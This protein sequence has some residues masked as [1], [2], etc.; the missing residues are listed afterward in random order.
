MTSTWVSTMQVEQDLELSLSF[1]ADDWLAATLPAPGRS[2]DSQ[3]ESPDAID[4]EFLLYSHS[5]RKGGACLSSAQTI[6]T[7]I[8]PREIN[9]ISLQRYL[10]EL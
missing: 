3:T 6:L 4:C 2:V 10:G 1:D 7:R 9:N 8:G 5:L